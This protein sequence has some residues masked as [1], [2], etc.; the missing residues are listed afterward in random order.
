MSGL[1]ILNTLNTP[2]LIYTMFSSVFTA[3]LDRRSMKM[4]MSSCF[5]NPWLHPHS[6]PN[7]PFHSCI[8]LFIFPFIFISWRLITLRCCRGLCLYMTQPRMCVRSPPGLLPPPSALHPSGSSQCA[9]PSACLLILLNNYGCSFGSHLF[10]C[11][12]LSC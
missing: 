2:E 10:I 1:C 9:S 5:S 7:S 12:I 8:Y 4:T 3:I 6:P 11:F